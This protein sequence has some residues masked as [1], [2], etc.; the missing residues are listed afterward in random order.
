M[1]N[2]TQTATPNLSR[3]KSGAYDV[4]SDIRNDMRGLSFTLN[5]IAEQPS[6]IEPEQIAV[7]SDMVYHACGA[8]CA[9]LDHMRATNGEGVA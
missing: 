3:G 1:M 9:V 5:A 6:T 2:Y 4:I 8:L 7:I